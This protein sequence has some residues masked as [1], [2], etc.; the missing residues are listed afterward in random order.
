MF[1]LVQTVQTSSH[2]LTPV[3]TGSHLFTTVHTSETTLFAQLQFLVEFSPW[4]S[5]YFSILDLCLVKMHIL[6]GL[7]ESFPTEFGMCSCNEI[8][9]SI[10]LGAHASRSSMENVNIY[11]FSDIFFPVSHPILLKLHILARLIESYP[12]TYGPKSCDEEKLS[13]PI[14]VHHKA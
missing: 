11:T 5:C 6:T 10:P 7:I 12:T 2:L 4:E 14:E 1:W 3:H 13:I 9:M 8:K